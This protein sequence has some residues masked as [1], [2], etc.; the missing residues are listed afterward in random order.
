M[1]ISQGL[2]NQWCN[3]SKVQLT[4]H[5][6]EEKDHNEGVAEVQGV[7]ERPSDRCLVDKVVNGEKEEVE[8]SGR[9][10]EEGAP[11]PAIVLRAE[12]VITEQDRG[13]GTDHQ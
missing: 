11:P 4:S 10:G 12:I 9:R 13:L 7:R 3:Q 5:E 8:A 6:G 2:S 1:W